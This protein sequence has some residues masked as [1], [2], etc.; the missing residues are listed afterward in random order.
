MAEQLDLNS[1]HG[2]SASR[3]SRTPGTASTAHGFAPGPVR[4]FD[5]G[6]SQSHGHPPGGHGCAE[7]AKATAEREAKKGEK[8]GEA[9]PVGLAFFGCKEP[10][11]PEVC[12]PKNTGFI[13]EPWL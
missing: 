5:E 7:A 10:P 12:K 13:R 2:R 4:D 1:I 11:K 3:G 9:V 8:G 6:H